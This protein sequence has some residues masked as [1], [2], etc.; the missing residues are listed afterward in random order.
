MGELVTTLE[1]L[2]RPGLRAAC[3]GINPA[4]KS[5]E[6]G[7]YY[8]GPLG[9][10]FFARLRH[11]GLVSSTFDGYE[12]DAAFADGIG[13]TDIVKRPTSGAREVKPA[14]FAH[15]RGL[16]EAKLAEHNPELVI[17]TFKKT[18]QT[19]FGPFAGN[20]FLPGLE[21]AHSEVFVMPGPYERA[22]TAAATMKQ[23]AQ[24][25]KVT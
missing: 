21:L 8:Q 16:L 18:A 7:H 15:G 4:P 22:G 17:F 13:F 6:A 11:A 2:L 5:V 10:S 9:Q 23:L 12:D 1:D 19:L 20:G 25:L 14:E 3:V 24:R